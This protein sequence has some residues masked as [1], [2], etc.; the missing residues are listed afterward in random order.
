MAGSGS[1]RGTA[2]YLASHT[3]A[4]TLADLRR[5]F[6]CSPVQWVPIDGRYSE[7]GFPAQATGPGSSTSHA[8]D[9]STTG[10]RSWEGLGTTE[11]NDQLSENH[12]HT[13]HTHW[14]PR[15]RGSDSAWARV[16]DRG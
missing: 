8:R 7:Y 11:L 4:G 5:E 12:T 13:L 10:V 1:R 15:R 2:F 14:L 6:H 16:Q 9:M 3:L